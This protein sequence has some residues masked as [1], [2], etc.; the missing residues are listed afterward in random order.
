MV[1]GGKLSPS[2]LQEFLESRIRE[3]DARLGIEYDDTERTILY[4]R[5]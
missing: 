1:D 5:I 2:I 4:E 3:I